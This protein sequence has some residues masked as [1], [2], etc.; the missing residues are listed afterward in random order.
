MV[1]RAID[2]WLFGAL[3]MIAWGLLAYALRF[4]PVPRVL[5]VLLTATALA[6]VFVVW[7]YT[8][9]QPR[10]GLDAIRLQ[11]IP[12]TAR[13]GVVEVVVR[14]SGSVAA[15]VVAFPVA[16]MAP[17]FRNAQELAAGRVEAELSERLMRA[18]RLPRSGAIAVPAGLTAALHVEIPASER[19]WYFQS[20]KLT[21]LVTARLQYRD[22]VFRRETVFCHFANPQS[23]QWLSCP[24]L[25]D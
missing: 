15:D 6:L 21:V 17:L 18:D 22:R 20:G 8:T 24:F 12:S 19:A 2:P 4:H 14:N 13:P 1:S 7:N 10:I 3:L 11:R 9:P 23:N 16:Y 25:N 5:R